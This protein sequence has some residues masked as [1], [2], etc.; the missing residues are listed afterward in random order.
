MTAFADLSE[1]IN[2]DLEGF[3]DRISE[4]AGFPLLMDQSYQ[5]EGHEGDTLLIRV[6]GDVSLDLDSRAN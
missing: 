2:L 3:L 5:V 6:R 4:D 1:I